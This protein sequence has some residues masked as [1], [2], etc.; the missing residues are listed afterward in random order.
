MATSYKDLIE[1]R[2]A[3]EKQIAEARNTELA[4]AVGK[5]RAIVAEY[6]LT[7]ADVFPA[8]GK[9]AKAGSKPGGKVAAKYRD[10]S[11]GA[12]WTGR[13]KS[14][15]WFDAGQKEKFAIAQA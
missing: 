5:V 15:R 3:L 11:T 1:Q 7:A 9:S 12:T 6:E 8:S 4:D 13:G 10:P 14:P 2:A